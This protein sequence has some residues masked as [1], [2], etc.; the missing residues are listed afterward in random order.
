MNIKAAEQ[1]IERLQAEVE[2]LNGKLN[3]N[4]CN[5][6]HETLPLYLWDCPECTRL[7]REQA[8][9]AQEALKKS[10]KDRHEYGDLLMGANAKIMELETEL[11][12]GLNAKID[13]YLER[14]PRFDDL[15]GAKLM[16]KRL[17]EAQE[18]IGRLKSRVRELE[19]YIMRGGK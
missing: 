1:E 15:P 17:D 5:A 2:R 12:T 4:R 16:Q 11:R 13:S 18:E 19:G 8:R 10:E 6:G 9:E 14:T 3:H 7:V